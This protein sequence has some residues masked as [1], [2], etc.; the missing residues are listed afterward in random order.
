MLTNY[1]VIGGNVHWPPNGR[2]HYDLDNTNAVLSS[3]EN[4]RID[5]TKKSFTNKDFARYRKL[6]PDC[7]GAW[8]VYWRQNF[9]GWKNAQ[10]DDAGGPMKNWWP[11]LFY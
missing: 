11:F 1:F 9:A 7:M 8:L 5:G 6:A 2:R 3:I 10:K 4:W